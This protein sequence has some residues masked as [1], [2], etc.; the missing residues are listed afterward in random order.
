M[1]AALI[2]FQPSCAFSQKEKIISHYFPLRKGQRLEA[3]PIVVEPTKSQQSWSPGN[4]YKETPGTF[5]LSRHAPWRVKAPWSRLAWVTH[6]ITKMLSRHLLAWLHM[7]LKAWETIW[8]AIWA[9][10]DTWKR[11]LPAGWIMEG[12]AFNNPFGWQIWSIAPSICS[13][14][15]VHSPVAA[16]TTYVTQSNYIANGFHHIKRVEW[17]LTVQFRLSQ[18]QE[19]TARLLG[20]STPKE[21]ICRQKKYE[22]W[23]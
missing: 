19:S 1:G 2:I 22:F 6:K 20:W 7:A 18:S 9:S 12:R 5:D 13:C 16:C 11:S 15:A 3:L 17:L 4:E 14:P 8:A 21:S 10:Q 23:T